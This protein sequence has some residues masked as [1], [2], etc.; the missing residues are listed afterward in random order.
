M[1][2]EVVGLEY[3]EFVH[4]IGDTHIY[5]NHFD[6]CREQLSR[7]MRPF[8]T[9]WNL[10]GKITDI[11][12]FQYEDFILEGYDPIQV[13]RQQLLYRKHLDWSSRCFFWSNLIL[14][15]ILTDDKMR[16]LHLSKKFI[17]KS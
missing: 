12:D 8:P 2:A 5:H 17:K 6:A 11:N 1:I 9:A 16:I 3:W 15:E 10:Q 13:L 14:N 7:D 4:V